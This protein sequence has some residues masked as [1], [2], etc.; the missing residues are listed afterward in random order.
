MFLE[1]KTPTVSDIKQ[2]VRRTALKRTFTPV[3]VGTALK[4]KGVQPLL[5][6]VLEYLPHPG[7]VENTAL[8]NDGKVCGDKCL[9]LKSSLGFPANHTFLLEITIDKLIYHPLTS[10]IRN[11]YCVLLV[12]T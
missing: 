2:A 3:L 1:E 11:M 12:P 6:A 9:V 4:N 10:R 5:D 7:E 8:M